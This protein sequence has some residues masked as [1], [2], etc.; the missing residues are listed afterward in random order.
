MRSVTVRELRDNGG[1]EL[2]RVQ[3]VHSISERLLAATVR[4][5]LRESTISVLEVAVAVPAGSDRLVHRVPSARDA[6]W[7]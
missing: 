1:E 3:R 2:D 5:K 7:N 4:G 6:G